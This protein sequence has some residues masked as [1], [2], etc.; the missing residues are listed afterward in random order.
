MV[1]T[2]TRYWW[3]VVLRGAFAL[4][5]GVVALVWPDITLIALVILFG[6][7]S[8]VDGVLSLYAAISGA[9]VGR[10]ASRGWLVVEGIAG[11]AIGVV[12]FIWPAVTA[13]V[14]L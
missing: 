12:T 8:L 1:E 14:L 4:L 6:A 2:L 9:R 3:V 11:V 13:L 5:F 7:Y 10:M